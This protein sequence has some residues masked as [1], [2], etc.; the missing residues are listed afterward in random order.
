M[1]KHLLALAALATVSGAVFAQNVTVYGTIDNGF[2]RTSKTTAAGLGKSEL[3]NGGLSPSI[4]GFRG[5][6]DLG[7]GLKANFALES[8]I[9]ADTGAGGTTWGG[10]FGRQANVGLSSSSGTLTLGKQFS[11]A[12]LAFAAT[13][14]RGLKETYSGLIT[15]LYSQKPTSTGTASSAGDIFMAN[16]VGLSTNVGGVNLGLAHSL[17]EAANDTSRNTSTA[18]SAVYSN[19]GVTVSAAAQ[20]TNGDNANHDVNKN[21]RQ[22]VGVAYTTGPLTFKANYLNVDLWNTSGVKAG[23]IETYGYGV[24]YAVN[25]KNTVTVA[26]YDSENKKVANNTSKTWIVSNDYSMSKRTTLYALV[27]GNKGGSA[28]SSADTAVGNTS[29]GATIAGTSNTVYQLGINH[30]F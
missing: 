18:Y 14:P 26:Y 28:F 12:V 1:K 20:V 22:T 10:L 4:F 6:E 25:A 24:N 21:K 8:H 16:A 23:E 3:H 15:W 19:S 17:G 7:G 27:A 30:K 2:T 13:D 5:T 11:P 9:A 29:M